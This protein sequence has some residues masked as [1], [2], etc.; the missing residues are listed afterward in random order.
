MSTVSQRAGVTDQSVNILA[1]NTRNGIICTAEDVDQTR[2]FISLLDEN[3]LG[4]CKTA[5][6]RDNHGNHNDETS[7]VKCFLLQEEW[8][9]WAEEIHFNPVYHNQIESKSYQ[10][11]LTHEMPIN[12]KTTCLAKEINRLH[13]IFTLFQ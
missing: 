12:L 1:W 2:S 9:L 7:S 13:P 5:V 10:I 11:S 6:T 3:K 4:F 8:S